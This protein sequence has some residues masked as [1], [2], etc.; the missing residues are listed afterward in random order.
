VKLVVFSLAL[1]GLRI[2]RYLEYTRSGK[3]VGKFCQ[4]FGLNKFLVSLKWNVIWAE[5]YRFSSMGKP[6]QIN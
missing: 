3:E 2:F 4:G 6:W 1:K 5:V